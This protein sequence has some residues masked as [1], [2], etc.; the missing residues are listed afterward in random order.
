[1]WHGRISVAA[2]PASRLNLARR[3]S[4]PATMFLPKRGN[5][6][7]EENNKIERDECLADRVMKGAQGMLASPARR[8][9]S[10]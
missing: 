3:I 5:S 10:G 1:M 9:S 7:A 4:Q 2:V 6:I 8:Y